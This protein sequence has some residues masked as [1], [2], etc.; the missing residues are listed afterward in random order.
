MGKGEILRQVFLTSEDSSAGA[1]SMGS[2]NTTNTTWNL[3]KSPLIYL[4]AEQCSACAIYS[5]LDLFVGYDH[6][7]LAGELRDYT[8]FDTSL[9]TMWLTVLSQGWTGL[10]EF[11]HNN[12]A[13]IL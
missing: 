3:Q 7:T 6:H 13:F 5:G 1:C 9:G 4:Y 12:I 11:F 10:V 8:T 2:K